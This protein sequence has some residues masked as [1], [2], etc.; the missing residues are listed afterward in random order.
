MTN[1]VAYSRDGRRLATVERERGVILWDVAS[2]K[3]ARDSRFVAPGFGDARACLNPEG[4]LLA[5][6]SIEGPVRLWTWP[7]GGRLPDSRDTTRALLTW[8]FIAAAAC[9]PPPE[10][11]GPSAS[12]MSTHASRSPSCAGTPARSVGWPSA[13]T[14][15][16][17][18]SGSHDK[19]ICLWDAQTHEQLA[20]IPAG[21]V[22]FGVAFSPDGHAAGSRLPR[23]HRPPFRRRPPPASRRA[24]RA[25]RLRPRRRLEPGRH[26][27]RLRLRDFTVRVLGFAVGPGTGQA[28]G[29]QTMPR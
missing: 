12:G 24:A 6:G 13:P 1:S 8:L 26:P 19:T 21:S 10:K 4:T 17:L 22:V 7:R 9:S 29:R 25:R 5:A 28:S 16:L 27:A 14:A 2:Q 20:V 11:T 18:A 3:P 23:Q 15:K